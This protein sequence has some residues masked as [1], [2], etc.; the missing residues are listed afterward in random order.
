VAAD[1]TLR[2]HVWRSKGMLPGAVH[3][4]RQRTVFVTPRRRSEVG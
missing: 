2:K 4:A 3:F 1:H